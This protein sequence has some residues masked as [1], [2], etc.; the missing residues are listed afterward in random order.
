[1]NMGVLT[2]PL[3]FEEFERLPDQ[4]GKREL[5]KGE[6]IELP[7][8]EAKHDRASHRIFRLLDAAL[9]QA[10]G[11]G[12][13]AALGEVFLEIGYRLGRD[14]WVKPDVSIT[15]AGQPEHKY[16]EESPAIAIEVVSPGNSAEQMDAKIDL[17]FE[18]G[19]GEVWLFYSKTRRAYIYVDGQPRV[20]RESEAITTPLLPGF[21]L[22][23]QD[24]L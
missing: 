6:V 4:P 24:V 13:A 7:P 17:Y 5:V 18:H 9:E 11:R 1:M 14:G 3:T 8:A 20:V 23:L 12:E 15:H 21:S 2:T 16:I 10:H 22:L 19:A